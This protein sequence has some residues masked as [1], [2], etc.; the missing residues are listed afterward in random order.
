M[1]PKS[2][3][4]RSTSDSLPR[5]INPA[6]HLDFETTLEIGPSIV[7]TCVHIIKEKAMIAEI[8]PEELAGA[9]DR[10]LRKALA[11]AGVGQP[12]VDA[13]RVARRLG[14]AVAW[15][16]RQAGRARRVTLAAAGQQTAAILLRHDPRVERE[17][18]AVAHE[19]G[20]SLAKGVFGELGVDPREAPRQSRE[21]VANSIASAILLPR[22]CFATDGP[23]LDWDLLA[24]K[25]RYC[26][27]S[28]ELIARRMLD[29][30]MPICISVYDQDRLTWRRSNIS[31]QRLPPS[32]LES[33]ARLRA[34]E[35]GE[36]VI[37]FGPPKIQVWPIHEAQWQRE[38]VR[39][40][41][42]KFADE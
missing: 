40:Q 2:R 30:S 21:I 5:S 32:S 20:E 42:D 12:P 17:Q 23:A 1:G 16:D 3:D 11:A 18:W 19:I 33:D 10:V 25:E 35:S 6:L 36:V 28:H 8:A 31:C 9:V 4:I 39:A 24:L 13:L 15:D 14:L 34:H 27:A 26:T 22:E 7:Y 41:I 29:C 38:I 37:E